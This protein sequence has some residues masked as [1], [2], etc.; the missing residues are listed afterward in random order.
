MES[1]I[2]LKPRISKKKYL[3]IVKKIKK[4]IHRGDIYEMNFCQEF[5]AKNAEINPLNLYKRLNNISPMP[6][7]C[8]YKFNHNYL[9]CSSPEGFLQKKG[10]KIFSRPIKGTIQRG[11]NKWE[12]TLLRRNLL[13]SK[14]EQSEN[15]M[16]VDLVRNDFSKFAKKGSVKVDELF[17]IYTFNNLHHMISTISCEV[18]YRYHFVDAIKNCFP[19]GSMTGAP[20]VKAMELI[21]KYEKTR[22]G[23]FSGA[24]GYITP[25]GDFDFNVVI[26]SI[27]FNK[28]NKYLSVMA[29]SAITSKSVPEKEY[30]ECLLKAWPMIKALNEKAK[31]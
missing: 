24:V 6:Y 1:E 5:Y 30:E 14:K 2:Q 9:L 20:K 19:M 25:E 28:K 18:G 4:H 7:S 31:T 17:G 22:R 27:L 15:V 8:F 13:N 10:N 12:D 11:K 26:R 29:G 21:E 23:L 16:I 3:G